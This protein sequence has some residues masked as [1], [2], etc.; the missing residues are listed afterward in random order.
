MDQQTLVYIVWLI[1]LLPLLSFFTI[2]LL[3][4]KHDRL[5]HSIAIGAMVISFVLAQ[6]IF[7]NAV[8]QGGSH[9]AAQP[10][11]VVEHSAETPAAAEGEH[12]YPAYIESSIPWLPQGINTLN[13]GVLVDPLTAAMLFMV[14]IACLMIFIYSVGYSNF[15]KK[16][17]DHDKPGFPPHQGREPMY[18]RF[19]AFLSLFAG[20]ML[21]LVVADNLLLLFIGWEIMGL[22]S[23]LLIG[24][25]YARTYPD[26][27]KITP[28]GAAVKAFMTTRVADVFML[29]GIAF[30]Y[31]STG[32]LSFTEIFTPTVTHVLGQ[33]PTPFLGF[34]MAAVIYLLLFIGTI[35]KSAQFPLHTWL[36]DAMEG[37]TPVSAMIHAAA[38]VSAGVYMVIRMFPILGGT[39]P[40]GELVTF[41]P[42][43]LIGTFTAAFAATI[44]FTQR[45]VKKVLAYSTISQ[46][47][48]MISALGMG[49]WVAA[50][51]HLITHAFFKALL[52][53][54]S[55]SIIHGVEHG[56]HAS[57]EQHETSAH[58]EQVLEGHGT[59]A[60]HDEH[61]HGHDDADPQEPDIDPQDMFN[62]GG[63]RKKMPA[64][65][66]TFLIGGLSLAGFPI[67]TAGFWSKDEIL[68]HAFSYPQYQIVFWTLVLTAFLTAFYT[69]R[70]ISLTFL[71]QPRTEAAGHAHESHWTMITPLVILAFFAIVAGWVGI[72]ADMPGLGL[73]I[74]G[75]FAQA[76]TAFEHFVEPVIATTIEAE[77][78]SFNWMPLLIASTAG[79][80][81]LILGW[82]VYGRKPLAAGQPD[83]LE[84][85]MGGL[86]VL[87]K[88]K[89]YI[90][91]IY[92]FVF[93]QPAKH[94]AAWMGDVFDRKGIDGV[95]HGIANGALRLSLA[96]RSFDTKVVNGGAD[97]FAASIKAAGH[98]L[99]DI[100]TGRVQ[101][102]LLLALVSVVLLI[103]LYITLFS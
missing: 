89:Y 93:V 74:Y 21:T 49:A 83:P 80:A 50:L 66:W 1:P 76:G 67:V 18:A 69:M 98:W 78:L 4:R 12:G 65:F 54:G 95:L 73:L 40:H 42:M 9:E 56:M 32:T 94:F 91:E 101:N 86:Y 19:F 41:T 7:W 10:A 26:P 45:D 43:I 53:M 27:N 25:W 77:V 28:R 87:L 71:G 51:F 5:S 31:S 38:M 102:Y 8:T 64:T 82:W 61:G 58:Y 2:M 100:Q 30:L 75:P 14:P 92:N 24:F 3:T 72:K 33:T 29:L 68:G 97:G 6:I 17:D 48:F 62:M 39:V 84:A 63:L 52:F 22:C 85:R 55:G 90:D 11:A 103:A 59:E 57:H 15:N 23:Y 35:G 44:A 60:A 88:N 13:M 79:I 20:A 96:F 70:Q 37:P 16:H 47:G 46:L 99:R 36:P 81:G 34:S